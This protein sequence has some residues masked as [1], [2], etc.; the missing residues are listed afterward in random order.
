MTLCPNWSAP[1]SAWLIVTPKCAY[2]FEYP[3]HSDLNVRGQL[4]KMLSPSIPPNSFPGRIEGK[5]KVKWSTLSWSCQSCDILWQCNCTLNWSLIALLSTP[6]V[7]I[8]CSS[9]LYTFW[10]LQR[11]L[12]SNTKYGDF[13]CQSNQACDWSPLTLQFDPK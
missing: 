8:V 1:G 4:I 9:V 7:C 11:S 2:F 5:H 10:T 3:Y 12:F 13:F 6:W